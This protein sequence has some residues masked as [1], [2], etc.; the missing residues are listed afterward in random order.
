MKPFEFTHFHFCGGSGGAAIGL[1]RSRAVVGQLAARARCLGGIDS[2][3]AACRDFRQLVGVDQAH[4]DL[5]TREQYEAFHEKAPPPGWRE[6]TIDD[7][8]RAAQGEAPDIIVISAPCKAF[9]KLLSEAKARLPKYQALNQLVLRCIHLALAAW[10]EDPPSLFLIEN[11]PGILG[12]GRSLLD[13]AQSL[14]SQAGYAA[15]ETTHCAGEIGGLG[16]RRLRFLMVARHREKVPA[17]LYEPARRRRR[18][19]GEVLSQMPPPSAPAGGPLHRLPALK[20]MTWLKLALIPAGKD[21]RELNKLNLADYGLLPYGEQ[22]A[23]ETISAPNVSCGSGAKTWGGGSMGVLRLDQAAGVITG[24]ANPT[25]GRFSVADRNWGNYSAYR[26]ARLDE[27]SGTITGQAAPGSGPFSIADPTKTARFNN[28]FRIVRW[29]EPSACINGGQT[30]TAGGPCVADPRYAN[31]A[32]V[33]GWNEVGPCVTGGANPM[34]GGGSVAD[35]R[36]HWANAGHYGVLRFDETSPCITGAASVD[37]G[38]SAVADPRWLPVSADLPSPLLIS[39]DDTWHRPLTILEMAALQGFDWRDGT[40]APLLLDGKNRAKWQTRIGNAIPPPAA[41]AIGGEM[42][43]TLL[44]SKIGQ[45]FSLSATPIW[46]RP[47]ALALTVDGE[48]Q[49]IPS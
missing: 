4:L 15:R 27:P 20:P 21:H 38:R 5:F 39:E 34:Q 31:V 36:P 10:E 40:G 41:Q 35:P 8:R 23:G 7:V 9:S 37:N 3:I 12:R 17:L 1:Q 19:I 22:G 49:E 26:I 16:Q 32:R 11:V 30:P 45:T 46:V 24:R 2:D 14:F 47:V 43:R 6:V 48:P 28:V 42:L 13:K 33:T 25:T 18:T 29:Q 44:L